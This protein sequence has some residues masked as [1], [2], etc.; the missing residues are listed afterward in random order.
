MNLD[1]DRVITFIIMWGIP[2]FMVVRTYFKMDKADK[3]SAKDELKTPRFIFTIGFLFVGL[4]MSQLGST[5]SIKIINIVGIIMLTIGGL[6]A[7]IDIWKRSKIK[8]MLVPILVIVAI[9]FLYE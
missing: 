6:I 7:T 1:I 9:F 3:I 4:F 8:S 5:L 2:I